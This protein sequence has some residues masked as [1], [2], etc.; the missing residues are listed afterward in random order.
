MFWI[1][2]EDPLKPII[3]RFN[4]YI[5]N[6]T[7]FP[8]IS[9]LRVYCTAHD[10]RERLMDSDDGC[11]DKNCINHKKKYS[12]KLLINDIETGLLKIWENMNF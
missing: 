9:E 10:G 5:D 3:Y 12:E 8:F 4:A 1:K 6:Y 7:N 11:P 2:F